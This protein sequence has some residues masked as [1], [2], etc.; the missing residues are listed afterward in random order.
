MKPYTKADLAD[1]QQVNTEEPP[2]VSDDPIVST[3]KQQQ[4]PT[5]KAFQR[6]IR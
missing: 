6:M 1:A 5:L 3:A 4:P 2:L